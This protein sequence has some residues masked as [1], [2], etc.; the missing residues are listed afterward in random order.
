MIDFI[1]T[2][3]GKTK[4]TITIDPTVW[5][6]DDRKIDLKQWEGESKN[7]DS[8]DIENYKKNISAQW[9]KEITEGAQVPRRD[10]TNRIRNKKEALIDGTFGMPFAPFLE[11]AE[12]LEEASKVVIE[13]KK[14]TTHIVPLEEAKEFVLGF[15]KNGKPLK[16][17]G[18]VHVYYGDGSNRDNPILHVKGFRIE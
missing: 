18:P 16:E 6:F 4:H 8:D 13:T 3:H 11:N 12:P 7:D 10:Q 1:V 2:I 14:N 15:S 17:N 5:I 9:D